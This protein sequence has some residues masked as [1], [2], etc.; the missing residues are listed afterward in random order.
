MEFKTCFDAINHHKNVEHGAVSTVIEDIK[1]TKKV[2][3]CN[4]VGNGTVYACLK[5]PTETP[6]RI[7]TGFKSGGFSK[8]ISQEQG[9][10]N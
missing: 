2:S 3:A 4:W 1:C 7:Y 8:I 10:N 6:A 9:K 5:E